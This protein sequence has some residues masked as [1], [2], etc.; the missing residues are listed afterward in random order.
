MAHNAPS[1]TRRPAQAT[2]GDTHRPADGTLEL[3]GGKHVL[4]FERRL[5]HPVERVW[6]AITEPAELVGWLAD[7][8]L[9]LVE[10]GAVELRWQNPISEELAAKYGIEL[11]DDH[12]PGEVPVVRG[13]ITRI[14][15]PRLIEY[16][17]DLHGL[18]RWELRPEGAGCVL[19]LT[20][21]L[22]P[23]EDHLAAQILAGWH[24][25]LDWLVEAL[26]GHPVDWSDWPIDHW[27]EH[28]DRYAAT[29]A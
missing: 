3:V 5:D 24:A 20:S 14:E 21:T 8:E 28:R 25:H 4:R 9:D 15:A 29:L 13:T 6:A 17:T 16:D 18:L 10:G 26:A 11:P 2:V 1:E 7:G 22:P 12:D 19:T 23:M 27:A